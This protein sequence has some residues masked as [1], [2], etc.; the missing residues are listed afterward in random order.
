MQTSCLLDI[1][2]EAQDVGSWECNIKFRHGWRQWNT[3]ITR[4]HVPGLAAADSASETENKKDDSQGDH[5][6]EAA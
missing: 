2:L 3:E 6:D 5:S 1:S 4:A